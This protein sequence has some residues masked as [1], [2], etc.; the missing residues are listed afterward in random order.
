MKRSEAVRIQQA[1]L[2]AKK[3]VIMKTGD[4][5]KAGYLYQLKTG[6]KNRFKLESL[7]LKVFT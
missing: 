2:E 3:S 5:A 4:R 6:T 7:N 1:R